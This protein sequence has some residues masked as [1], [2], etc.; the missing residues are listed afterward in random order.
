[1][2]HKDR[3]TRLVYHRAYYVKHKDKLDAQNKAYTEAHADKIKAYAAQWRAE[4]REAL[5]ARKREADALYRAE[6]RE[7][8]HQRH[9]T[10][11][12]NN[13][14]KERIR[15]IA[16]RANNPEKRRQTNAQWRKTH[17]DI[18]NNAWVRYRARKKGAPQNDLTAAQWQEIKE[19]YGHC[20]VYCGRKMQRL[21]QD[22]ITPLS[23][24]GS[25][26]TSNVVPACQG[27]NS[28]KGA[29]QPLKP[30]Q[31]L[32]L[33]VAPKKSSPTR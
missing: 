19:A 17:T 10:Y 13:R 27:C 23:R 33:T 26:T 30:I 12:A 7:K 15:S 29:G 31:P 25:H 16:Y 32:L 9:I 21:T 11:R 22:H 28:K 3:E 1:M 5:L 2:P 24:G 20:C 4:N 14:E 8:E 18:A 6:N